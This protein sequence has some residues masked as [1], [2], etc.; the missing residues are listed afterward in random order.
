MRPIVVLLALPAV[1]LVGCSSTS[2]FVPVGNG[3]YE[4]A[5]HSATALSSGGAQR[6]RLIEEANAYCA[7]QGLRAT[8]VGAEDRDGKLGDFAAIS[9]PSHH[10][11]GKTT[12]TYATSGE[13]A[14]ADVRF[15]CE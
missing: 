9:V 3:V 14:T 12:A 13:R 4:V 15:R 6:I 11:S 5:G 10:H 1:L 2:R 7:R 8:V